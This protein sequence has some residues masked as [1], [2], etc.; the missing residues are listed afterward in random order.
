MTMGVKYQNLAV[1]IINMLK[2]N[3]QRLKE[4][5][6]DELVNQLLE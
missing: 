4:Q 1:G 3:N 2:D 5:E 6:F